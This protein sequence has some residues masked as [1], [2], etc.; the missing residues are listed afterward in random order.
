M[1]LATTPDKIVSRVGAD[2]FARKLYEKMILAEDEHRRGLE[3]KQ[4]DVAAD[5][6]KFASQQAN[7]RIKAEKA[8]EEFKYKESADLADKIARKQAIVTAIDDLKKDFSDGIPGVGAWAGT[9]SA[10]EWA[11]GVAGGSDR[12][13]EFKMRVRNLVERTLRE[14]TGANAPPSEVDNYTDL[15]LAGAGDIN[16]EAKVWQNLEAFVGDPMAQIDVMA[17]GRSPEAVEYLTRN[18]AL[19]ERDAMNIGRAPTRQV[20]RVK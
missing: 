1:K 6:E 16:G 14:A 19:P 15:M 2:P 11:S 4:V 8:G 17:R 7:E 3:M 12:A 5:R 20:V 10:L 9:E 18:K 13:R